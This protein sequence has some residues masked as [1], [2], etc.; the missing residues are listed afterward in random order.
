MLKT[1]EAIYDNRKLIFDKEEPTV[2]RAR[3]YL[4]IIEET[5]KNNMKTLR[6]YA[7]CISQKTARSI[8]R[9]VNKNC[10]KI[11]KED[12]DNVIIEEVMTK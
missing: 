1:F 3:V 7:G 5:T 12:W 4:T 10:E 6:K 2:K 9:A 8:K 11:Q